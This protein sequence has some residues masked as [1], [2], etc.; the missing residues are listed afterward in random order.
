MSRNPLQSKLKL[1]A[2]SLLPLVI[3]VLLALLQRDVQVAHV[4][5]EPASPDGRLVLVI[6]DSLRDKALMDHMPRTQH[7]IAGA[8]IKRPV[9]TCRANFSLP[10]IR[11]LLEGRESPFSAGLHNFTGQRGGQDNLPAMA[12][13]A[14]LG[15]AL[16]SD[17]TLESLYGQD[18]K[19]THNIERWKGSRLEKDER[20]IQEAMH[21]LDDPQIDLVVLHVVGTDKAA[22][23][24]RV[25]HPDYI[26]EYEGV[27]AALAPLYAKL[28]LTRDHLI[29]TGDHGHDQNGFH[30]PYSVALL[31]G[32]RFEALGDQSVPQGLE[33]TDLLGF[34]ALAL[35]LPLPATFEG[36][37]FTDA[38]AIPDAAIARFVARQRGVLD[39]L[40][41]RGDTLSQQLAARDQAR[42]WA[43]WHDMARISPWFILYLWT[44]IALYGALRTP[45][46]R[47]VL[48]PA[49]G[50]ALTALIAAL[51]PTSLASYAALALDAA[52]L[53]AM[54]RDARRQQ[55]VGLALAG[56]ALVVAAGLTSATGMSWSEFFHMNPEKGR[57][58][59]HL[60]VYYVGWIACGAAVMRLTWRR[61]A[62]MPEALALVVAIALPSGV[63]YYNFGQNILSGLILGG[64]LL[65][66][67]RAPQALAALRAMSG[68]ERASAALLVV[69]SGLA[70]WQRGSAWLWVHTPW[71]RLRAAPGAALVCA[72]AM[73]G[74]LVWLMRGARG[75]MAA[76]AA[77]SL[78]ALLYSVGFADMP[79]RDLFSALVPSLVVAAALA[80]ARTGET[81]RPELE[82]PASARHGVLLAL[83]MLAAAWFMCRGYLLNNLDFRFGL[84][85]F[86]HLKHEFEVALTVYALTIPKYFLPLMPA[87][88]AAW[89]LA[90]RARW[91]ALMSAALLLHL[92]MM[93]LMVQIFAGPMGGSAKLHELAVMDL[94]FVFHFVLLLTGAA[95]LAAAQREDQDTTRSSS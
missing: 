75:R 32:P 92:K 56:L 4:A 40:G 43:P 73:S 18:A 95:A 1:I 50:A 35:E 77:V 31:Q 20:A 87:V 60:L 21:A 59:S 27:D 84:E 94:V 62:A 85:R 29:I 38:P 80:L 39:T 93:A 9:T 86:G 8:L 54:L 26:K 57:R 63:Y 81:L 17:V 37:L 42:A 48:W 10:C 53:A 46:A 33:Q 89:L 30:D 16:I 69:G 65:A 49:A 2:A 61:A 74:A 28:D 68:A 47:P 88:I 11:T 34:M 76:M 24:H 41:W 78:G 25:G 79:A 83:G 14:G 7:P 66:V 71:E 5:P 15:V 58:W 64:A 45:R 67:A 72:I 52:L 44:L 91:A 13:G 51:M 36:R 12:H 90:P 23:E 6:V 3:T 82:G 55:M 22:H 19:I 70:M